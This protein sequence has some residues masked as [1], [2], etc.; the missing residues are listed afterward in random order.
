[1]TQREVGSDTLSYEAALKNTLRQAPDVIV[2][3]EIRDA[4][5]MDYAISFAETGHLCVSTLYANNANQ[6]LDR[7]INFFPQDRRDQLLMDL[8]LNLRGTV[9]QRLIPALDGGRALCAEILLSTAHISDLIKKGEVDK[10][11][12]AMAQL[13]TS[14]M[15]TFDQA[16][17]YLVKANHIS[18]EEALANADSQNNL[19]IALKGRANKG[20]ASDLRI[21]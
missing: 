15:Q 20:D 7:I 11:K 3:G 21:K 4:K 10:L 9:S 2:I 12:G 17:E 18:E 13:E 1:M 6:A 19:R 14:G 16:L 8:S 5:T